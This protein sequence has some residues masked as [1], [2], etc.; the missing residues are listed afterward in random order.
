MVRLAII[1]HHHT[2]S[3]FL[4]LTFNSRSTEIVDDLNKLEREGAQWLAEFVRGGR[5]IFDEI[6]DLRMYARDEI[7]KRKSKC[8]SPRSAV[9]LHNILE[10]LRQLEINVYSMNTPLLEFFHAQRDFLAK[11]ETLTTKTILRKKDQVLF[12]NYR[13]LIHMINDI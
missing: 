1:L 3:K 4:V 11:A 7:A 6:T 5:D 8:D 13:I 12:R 9:Y 2:I 10:R